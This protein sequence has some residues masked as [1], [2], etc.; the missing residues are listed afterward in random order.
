M[1]N[2]IN[3][4]YNNMQIKFKL[5][6]SEKYD[7]NIYKG[8]YMQKQEISTQYFQNQEI[9][10]QYIQNQEIPNN[11]IKKEIYTKILNFK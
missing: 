11:Y 1:K 3:V 2:T 5:F 6:W 8:Q 9:S 4:E 7:I 10:T